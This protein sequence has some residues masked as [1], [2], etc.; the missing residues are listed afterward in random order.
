MLEVR[1]FITKLEQGYTEAFLCRAENGLRYVTKTAR[2]GRESLI[3][4]YICGQI[5]TLLGLPIPPFEILYTSESIARF[6]AADELRDLVSVPG[7]GSRFITGPETEH[8]VSLPALNVADIADIPAG[9]SR[10]VL[11]FD[12]WIMNIDR[13]DG[14]TNLLWEPRRYEL[15]VI[16][17]NLSF[18]ELAPSEF[19][20]HHLFRDDGHVL[21]DP[22]FRALVS[23]V[24]QRILKQLP[25]MWAG[26]PDEWTDSCI[27][28]EDRV[29][30][31]LRRFESDGF[32]CAR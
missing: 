1:E 21:S 20:S 4:E 26:L 2:A 27:L 30:R 32:W 10:A 8:E 28:T 12:W 22:A 31:I 7:F 18:S 5:G 15:H 9:M 25:E 6:S 14:N 29:D 13:I 19:W 24:M 17:H 3:R 16:D 23:P 11:L